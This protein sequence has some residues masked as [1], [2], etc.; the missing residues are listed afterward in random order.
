M[1]NWKR[2]L[3]LTLCLLAVAAASV[4]IFA[5][6]ESTATPADATVTTAAPAETTAPAPA[7][8]T[9]APAETTT[10]AP[11]Y[12]FQLTLLLDDG[13]TY[14][15]LSQTAAAA[16]CTFPL[17]APA[18]TGYTFKGWSDGS[19]LYQ[20]AYSAAPGAHTLRAVWEATLYTITYVDDGA[21]LSTG[22]YTMD[23][24]TP[25]PTLNKTG[26][27]FA[28]WALNGQKLTSALPAGL[29][30]NITLT[31]QWQVN[32]YTIT[33]NTTGG[34]PLPTATYTIESGAVLPT[35]TRDGYTFTG[36]ATLD[37]QSVA[38]I[39]PA[40][41][42]DI[43]LFAKWQ[44]NTY[45]IVFDAAG[46]SAVAPVP[47]TIETGA[48]LPTPVRAGYT[49]LGWFAADGQKV[50]SIPSGRFGDVALTAQWLEQS[51]AI[52]YTA[53]VGGSLSTE[54]ELVGKDTG[55]PAS[56]PTAA[57]G[58]RFAGWY[59]D[60]AY[61]VPVD[62]GWVTADGTLHPQKLGGL[63]ADAAYYAKFELLLGELT[64]S[65]ACLD[66]EQSLI[67]TVTGQP[68]A[69]ELGPISLTVVIPA[70]QTAVTIADLPVGVYTISAQNGWS[71][72]C[73]ALG[74]LTLLVQA[75]DSSNR[76]SF[77]T[78]LRQDK[79]RWLNDCIYDKK[80]NGK[81]TAP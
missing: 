29:C 5:E 79:R 27:T 81:E 31:A 74:D 54:A 14:Q 47:Y 80:E 17:A 24:V 67:F 43:T 64:I 21:V 56:S 57:A 77:Q 65:A 2:T 44:A 59:C 30:G 69:A 78:T 7:E 60:A 75:G 19:A 48:E 40:A 20:T 68:S 72:R 51:A 16:T 37:G 45:T 41:Y 3:T 15:T 23:S 35:P 9:A 12:S 33:F 70:G 6:G 49:F 32:T 55:T 39:P 22:T 11:T 46:G 18:K 71:W 58:Y 34:A 61:T 42:G 38:L 25:L 10:P 62:A 4:N 50:S 73:T 36:W 1:L 8:T 66:R 52:T 13:T 63:H 28:G 26:Y 76:V 53:S